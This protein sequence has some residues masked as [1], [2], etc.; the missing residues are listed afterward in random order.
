[1][2]IVLRDAAQYGNIDKI[3]EM[4][5]EGIDMNCADVV[6]KQSKIKSHQIMHLHSKHSCRMVTH[7]SSKL[8]SME[9]SVLACIVKI[10]LVAPSIEFPF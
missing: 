8:Y 7:Q 9:R 3:Q 1:M 4:H 5:D 6:R 2:A 10:T